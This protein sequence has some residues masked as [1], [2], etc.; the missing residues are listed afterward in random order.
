MTKRLDSA[1]KHYL[2]RIKWY[3]TYQIT[4]YSAKIGF[5]LAKKT[6]F[7]KIYKKRSCA[8]PCGYN[9]EHLHW[10][11]KIFLLKQR[12]HYLPPLVAARTKHVQSAPGLAASSGAFLQIQ[13][14]A[15]QID[16]QAF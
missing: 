4:I 6:I 10:V 9:P 8:S 2:N 14:P 7:Y 1:K 16:E 11:Q 15:H 13:K 5:I 3:F 12:L